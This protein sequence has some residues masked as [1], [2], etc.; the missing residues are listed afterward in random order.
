MGFEYAR[1]E[2]VEE[3]CALL[4]THGSGAAVLSGGQSLIPLLRQRLTDYDCVVDINGLGDLDYISCDD[5]T[6]AIGCLTR[7]RDVAGSAVVGDRCPLL[8]DATADIGDVQ[9]RNRGTLC[10][11]LAHADPAGDPPVASVALGAELVA[12]SGE[13][14]RVIPAGQFFEGFYETALEPDELVVEA[15]FPTMAPNQGGAHVKYEP[16][17]GAYP[18]ATVS[19]VVTVDDG[20]ASE[21]T[22]VVGGVEEKPT[23]LADA[24]DRVAG[25]APAVEALVRAAEQAGADVNPLS[26]AEGSAAYKRELIKPL[27]KEALEEAVERAE[28]P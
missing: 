22:I 19:T 15:R 12:V 6:I 26:D 7:H 1:P 4:D 17:A 28:A 2:S 23:V 13:R 25:E 18:T 27:V 20:V 24:A 14:E 3:A 16:S 8:V 10:G 21:V 9:V 11:S 5:G